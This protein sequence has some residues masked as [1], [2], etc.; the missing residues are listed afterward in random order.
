MVNPHSDTSV[1]ELPSSIESQPEKLDTGHTDNSKGS[2]D[3]NPEPSGSAIGDH[4]GPGDHIED[5]IANRVKHCPRSRIP[6]RKVFES[7]VSP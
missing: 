4:L 3:I 2:M 7:C 6:S 1:L 5:T